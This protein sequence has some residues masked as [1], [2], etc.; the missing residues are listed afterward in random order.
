MSSFCN[1][2]RICCTKE[3]AE[4]FILSFIL[5]QWGS[6]ALHEAAKSGHIEVAILLLG[7]GAD[8]NRKTRIVSG[9]RGR[10]DMI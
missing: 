8:V 5:Y 3:E 4:R 7:K 10:N 9:M 6:T 1:K 2:F